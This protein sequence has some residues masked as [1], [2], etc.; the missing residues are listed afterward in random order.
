[1]GLPDI[2]LVIAFDYGLRHIGVAL[3]Q[4]VTA[5]SRGIA[6]IAARQGKP[7]WRA[8]DALIAQYKPTQVVVGL[9]LNMDGSTSD[10]AQRAR[11]FS[12]QLANR[13]HLP[14]SLH[15]E[16]LSSRA[17]RGDFE[18]AKAMGVANTEHE[19][20]ACLILNSWFAEQQT[21]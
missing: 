21:T 19:L 10:M 20:A 12:R 5:D 13:S 9:P 2:G 6:T 11:N 1:M 17:A 14:V 16:R 18:D 3:G 15:D 8:V 4:S 7:D